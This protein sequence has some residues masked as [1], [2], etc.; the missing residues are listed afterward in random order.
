[1][2][3]VHPGNFSHQTKFIYARHRY[4]SCP[5]AERYYFVMH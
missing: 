4:S 1:L 3:V 5:P 2:D